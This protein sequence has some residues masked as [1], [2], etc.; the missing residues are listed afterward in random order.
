[1]KRYAVVFS[2]DAVADLALSLQ[3]GYE[4]WGDEVARRWYV[5]LRRAIWE[6]L[7]T[8]P[9]SQPIAPDSDEYEVEVRQMLVGRYRI[10]FNLSKTTVTVLHVRGPYTGST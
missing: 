9:L 4:N 2:E 7:G 3:W 10:L 8:F 5:D 1:M 6:M